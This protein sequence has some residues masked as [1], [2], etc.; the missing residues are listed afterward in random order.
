MEAPIVDR[1]SFTINSS[2][3]INLDEGQDTNSS[4][5]FVVKDDEISRL[6]HEPTMNTQFIIW[7]IM[8]DIILY[9]S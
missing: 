1:H 7:Q 8:Y 3:A 9:Y 4:V 5:S 6:Y 2:Y